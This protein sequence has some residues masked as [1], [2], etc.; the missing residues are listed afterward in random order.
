MKSII[1]ITQRDLSAFLRTP[2]G[3]IIIAVILA[4]DGLLFSAVA[5]GRSAPLSEQALQQFF[6]VTS[7]ATMFACVFISMRLVAEERQLGTI[8][9]L[10][11]SPVRD[12]EFVLG[13]FLAAW[14]FIGI[15]L[16]FTCYMP[17][18]L[19]VYGKVSLAHILTGYAGCMLLGGAV[20]SI[21]VLC[22]ALAPNQL[23]SLLLTAG[24]VV[25]LILL[26]MLARV[27]DPPFDDLIA[28]LS[29]HDKHFQPFMRGILSMRDVG[30]YLSIMYVALAATTRV[31]E[32]RRWR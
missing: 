9:L 22:S 25:V 32:A 16:V 13:K 15:F 19:Y 28:Y 17:I 27:A 2:M 24:I 29:I 4:V 8:T 11:T 1:A 10:A 5:L 18:L 12:Y 23:L 30:F 7:G 6:Y 14:I 21:G 26:W 31:L 3:Y 20:L